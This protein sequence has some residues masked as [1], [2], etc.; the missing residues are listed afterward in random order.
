MFRAF[1]ERHDLIAMQQVFTDRGRSGYRDEHRKKGR[2]GQLIAMAKDGRFEPGTVI[3]V[4]AWDRLGRLRPDAM[5]SLISD[6]LKCDVGIGVCRLDDVFTDQDFGTHKWLTLAVFVQL[7][8][9]ESKQKSER[10]AASWEHRRSLARKDGRLLTTVAP[11][12]IEVVNGKPRLIPERAAAVKKI[13]QLAAEGFGHGRLVR[14]LNRLGVKPFGRSGQWR[15]SYVEDILGNRRALGEF[16]PKRERE[17]TEGTGTRFVLE[18]AGE[19]IRKFFPAAVTERE[20]ARARAAQER[21][22]GTDASGRAIVPR[23]RKYVNVFRGMIRHARDNETM[24]LHNR[25]TPAKPQLVL[26]ASSDAKGKQTYSF[27]YEIFE[28]VVLACLLEL[29]ASEVLP[30]AKAKGESKADALRA[31]LRNVRGDMEAIKADLRK[32]YSPAL[33]DV[34]RDKEAEELRAAEALQ[35]ELAQSERPAESAWRELPHVCE[36]IAKQGD[37]ARLR[38]HPVLR[39]LV[40]E[41]RVLLLP[42]GMTQYAVV[43]IFFVGGG[44]RVVTIWRKRA[45]R[46]RQGGWGADA[47]DRPASD[48]AMEPLGPQHVTEFERELAQAKRDASAAL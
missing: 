23:Q 36:L 30:K 24:Y 27:P 31:E 26:I 22:L 21:R 35:E 32:A 8:Y 45:L 14:E 16:Q 9:Q 40:R 48:G 42:Q 13:Y 43:Q 17:I 4:E 46:R 11:S 38:L 39:R 18:N 1:C 37:E 19:P 12:W 29:D 3:V 34:L 10:A 28:T 25:G 7:A 5:T 15:S 44:S 6:L 2:L 41:I 47:F 33:T 20:F